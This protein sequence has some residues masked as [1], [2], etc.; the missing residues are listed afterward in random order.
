MVEE[1]DKTVEQGFHHGER[2]EDQERSW[3]ESESFVGK[4]AVNVEVYRIRTI[5]FM[6]GFAHISVTDMGRNLVLI[7]SPKKGEVEKQ[8]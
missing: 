1:E 7:H 2:F 6:E 4:L 5:L 3:V 8:S